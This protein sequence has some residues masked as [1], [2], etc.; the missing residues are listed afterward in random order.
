MNGVPYIDGI[1]NFLLYERDVSLYCDILCYSYHICVDNKGLIAVGGI[2]LLAVAGLAAGNNGAGP[3]GQTSSTAPSA[4]GASD[5]PP[6]VQEAR[7]WIAAWK[8]KHG[9]A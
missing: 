9:K 1:Q 7:A 5:V 4:A 8:K 6:N 3:E 2:A